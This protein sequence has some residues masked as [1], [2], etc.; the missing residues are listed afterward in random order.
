MKDYKTEGNWITESDGSKVYTVKALDKRG[1][2]I[3]KFS[4]AVSPERE[5]EYKHYSQ[6]GILPELEKE[7]EKVMLNLLNRYIKAVRLR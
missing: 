3:K 1:E 5:Q 2:M 4:I 6:K 7:I